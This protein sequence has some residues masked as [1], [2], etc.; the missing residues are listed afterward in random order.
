MRY[1]SLFF[2]ALFFDPEDGDDIF[3]RNV[4]L[5]DLHSVT[6]LCIDT[7][8]RASM[9]TSRSFQMSPIPLPS[10]SFAIHYPST[11]QLLGAAESNS[12]ITVI[13][14]SALFGP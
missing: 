14:K 10:K 13:G 11:I 6:I 5:S 8:E 12:L 1:G 9:Y 7:A 2:G 4:G 3:L